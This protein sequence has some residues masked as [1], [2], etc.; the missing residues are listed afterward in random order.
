MAS[1]PISDIDTQCAQL[2]ALVREGIEKLSENDRVLLFEAIESGYC[3]W[4]GWK[5]G[6]ETCH[7]T[8]D[9]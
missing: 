8:N 1:D 5:R 7:C 4:C 9:E 2:L 3:R 6:N